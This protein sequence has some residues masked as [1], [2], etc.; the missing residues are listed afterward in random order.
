MAP[1]LLDG[2]RPVGDHV[3]RDGVIDGTG[4]PDLVG[5]GIP[6]LQGT[7]LVPTAAGNIYLV[8]HGKAQLSPF[9]GRTAL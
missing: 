3:V 9:L 5:N 2:E 1:G 7:V 6:Q 8:A 4:G